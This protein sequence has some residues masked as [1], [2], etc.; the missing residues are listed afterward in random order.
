MTKA[1][2]SLIVLFDDVKS[3]SSPVR[4]A[5]SR[6][7]E[8][9]IVASLLVYPMR[10]ACLT[11]SAEMSLGVLCSVLS[12]VPLMQLVPT[13]STMSFSAATVGVTNVTGTAP[14]NGIPAN[15]WPIGEKQML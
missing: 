6:M 13:W 11:M 9:W 10:F 12:A 5:R 3:P 1:F 14:V 15:Y 8:R 4:S 2:V 7:A